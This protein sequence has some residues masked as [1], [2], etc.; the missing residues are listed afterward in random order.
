MV[1]TTDKELIKIQKDV[2]LS[3]EN[4]V[5][6]NTGPAPTF[7]VFF[8][9]TNNNYKNDKITDG[10]DNSPSNITKLWE[11]YKQDERIDKHYEHGVGTT[12]G[13]ANS[14]LD[15]GFAYSFGSHLQNGINALLKYIGF[16]PHATKIIIDVFG[17]SRGAALA[18]HL[19]NVLNKKPL[20]AKQSIRFLG[21]FDT[22]GSFGLPGNNIDNFDLCIP[23]NSVKFVYHLIAENE[24]RENFDLHS[25]RPEP[26]VPLDHDDSAC[27]GNRWAVEILCPGVHSDIGGG[28]DQLKAGVKKLE[29]G[30]RNNRLSRHYLKQ[31]HHRAKVC[32]VPFSDAPKKEFN[33]QWNYGDMRIICSSIT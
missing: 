17:F 33:Q 2:Y 12:T 4:I 18:R 21:L 10:N 1:A 31:M 29:H 23:K 27:T 20:H 7:G 8:D 26:S 14:D 15:A 16:Y 28:Y 11:L 3:K 22:V 32:G 25:I 19:I 24:L 13:K 6:L 30:N 9:G 5:V